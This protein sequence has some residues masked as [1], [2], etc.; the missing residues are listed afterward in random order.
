MNENF[1][2]ITKEFEKEQTIKIGELRSIHEQLMKSL[3]AD[4]TESIALHNKQIDEYERRLKESSTRIAT[5]TKTNRKLSNVLKK[6]FPLGL[7]L[8]CEL[9]NFTHLSHPHFLSMFITKYY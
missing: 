1:N 2:E 6:S 4:S 3:T 7:N 9:I 5:A 8:T